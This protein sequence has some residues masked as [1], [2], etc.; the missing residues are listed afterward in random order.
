ML[1]DEVLDELSRSLS[2]VNSLSADDQHDD[3][4]SSLR[5]PH[6]NRHQ[7]DRRYLS[8]RLTSPNVTH[9]LTFIE[10]KLSTSRRQSLIRISYPLLS[11]L[12]VWKRQEL[13]AKV[14]SNTQPLTSELQNR[15]KPFLRLLTTHAPGIM[16]SRLPRHNV[17]PP[18]H[19][20]M[21]R[22]LKLYLQAVVH[23]TRICSQLM[24]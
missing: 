22:R 17:S 14:R 23:I 3:A 2:N 6:E 12:S 5:R 8:Q 15:L 24:L 21:Y 10:Q 11:S 18:H 20:I 1:N 9:G 16:T 19:I 4:V 7:H 13:W